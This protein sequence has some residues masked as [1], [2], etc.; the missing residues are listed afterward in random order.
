MNDRIRFERNP[1]PTF[2]NISHGELWR[3]IIN[4]IKPKSIGDNQGLP[5]DL[6]SH[7]SRCMRKGKKI[8]QNVEKG[9]FPW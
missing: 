4:Q 6:Y 1:S 8:K 3:Y 5:D 7:Y 2:D 9:I